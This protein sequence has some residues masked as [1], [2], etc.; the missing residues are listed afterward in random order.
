MRSGT[1]RVGRRVTARGSLRAMSSPQVRDAAELREVL[2][3]YFALVAND[4][5]H[6]SRLS[7]ALVPMRFVIKDLPGTALTAWRPEQTPP[8]AAW[9]WS[10][11]GPEPEVVVTATSGTMLKFFQGRENVVTAFVRG[12]IR[13]KG[14][15]NHVVALYPAIKPNF[16]RFRS[17]LRDGG[18][19]HLLAD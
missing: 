17:L 18:W 14:D 4:P 11:N 15:R 8:H 6:G 3:R 1:L 2:D 10:E 12:R 7:E 19:G 9:T 13:I 5:E 16:E